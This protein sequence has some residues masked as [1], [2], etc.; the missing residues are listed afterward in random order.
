MLIGGVPD[1]IDLPHHIRMAAGF[2]DSLSNGSELYP[3]WIS[4]TNDGFGDPSSRFYPPLLYILITLF[5]YLSFDWANSFTLTFTLLNLI[6]AAGIFLWVDKLTESKVAANVSTIAFML[7]PFQ[8]TLLFSGALFGHYTASVFIPYVFYFIYKLCQKGEWKDVGGIGLAL[9]LVVYSH[10]PMAIYCVICIT[11]YA[12]VL[13]LQNRNYV[14]LLKLMMGAILAGLSSA[15]YWV[16][17]LSELKWKNP[18]GTEQGDWFDYRRNFLFQRSSNPDGDWWLQ[19]V[20]LITGVLFLPTLILLFRKEKRTFIFFGLILFTFFMATV[21]SRFIWDLLPFLQETQF[22]WRWLTMS[23]IFLAVLVGFS[24][25]H[26]I[27]LLKP[28]SQRLGIIL[29]GLILISLSFTIFQIIKAA[30]YLNSAAFNEKVQTSL[31]TRTNQDFLPVWTTGNLR[32]MTNFIEPNQKI[33]VVEWSPK[34]HIFEIS[35]GTDE[36]IKLKLLYYPRWKVTTDSNETLETFP[37]IDGALL[38]SSPQHS[39][40]I[41]VEFI[42]PLTIKIATIVSLITL[43]ISLGLLFIPQK[44]LPI[45]LKT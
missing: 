23:S 3:S 6:G 17:M 42:E 18:S 20:A 27:E 11:I 1:G 35:A 40:L 2:Y 16:M 37:G 38:I 31:S 43:F 39:A 41:S 19:I 21:P 28:P 13:W 10:L 32:S 4:I 26:I 34:K 33:K 24:T 25:L 7:A 12:I 9:A 8:A 22:P 15:G 30:N 29:A 44:N 5:H 14:L 45:N 36:P